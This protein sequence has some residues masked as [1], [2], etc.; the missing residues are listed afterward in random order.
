MANYYEKI[1]QF[2]VDLAQ[3]SQQV[4]DQRKKNILSTFLTVNNRE[5][6]DSERAQLETLFPSQPDNSYQLGPYG[7]TLWTPDES[8]RTVENDDYIVGIAEFNNIKPEKR[9][10]NATIWYLGSML[11]KLEL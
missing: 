10:V 9:D 3:N 4:I 11:G 8:P 2:S 6:T 7:T 5:P 1:V